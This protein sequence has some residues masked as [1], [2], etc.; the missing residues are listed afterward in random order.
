[1]TWLTLALWVGPQA[2]EAEQLYRKTREK[3]EKSGT[4]QFS[5][6]LASEDE[7]WKG[8]VLL[9]KGNRARVEMTRKRAEAEYLLVMVSDGKRLLWKNP[10]RSLETATPKTMR[11]DVADLLTKLGANEDRMEDLFRGRRAKVERIEA[12]EFRM[13]A[14]EKVDGRDAQEIRYKLAVRGRGGG[15]AVRLWIDLERHLPLKRTLALAERAPDASAEATETYTA[16]KVGE[17]VDE[18]KFVIPKK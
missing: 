9:G 5:F 11:A 2:T 1:M 15:L 10:N 4:V 16:W 17:P 12:K 3:L 7:R 18:S 14:R 6:K 8:S 13:G